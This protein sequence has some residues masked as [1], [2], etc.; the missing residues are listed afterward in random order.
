MC[1]ER[2]ALVSATVGV[3][4]FHRQ[5][6]FTTTIHLTTN[7]HPATTTTTTIFII[8]PFSTINVTYLEKLEV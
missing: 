8:T 7:H 6:T 5:G 4:S 1:A 2:V 3:H